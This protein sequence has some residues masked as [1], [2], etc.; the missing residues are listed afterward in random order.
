MW[1]PASET[2]IL[3]A[4]EAED[5]GETATFDAKVAL[6]AKGKS[7]DLAIDVAAMANDGGT[8]L[9]GIGEDENRRPTIPQPFRLAGARERVDQI[10]RTSISEPPA[11][12]VHA[13]PT[14]D[15]LSLG[16]LLVSVPPSLRA[17]H[18][19]TVG[20]EYR[21]YGRGAT[22]NTPLSEGEVA[23]LY[24]RRQRWEIDRSAMLEQVI[25]LAQIPP[26]EDYAFLHLIARPVVPDEDMLDKAR[27]DQHVEQFLNRQ[28]SDA[29]SAKVFSTRYSPDLHTQQLRASC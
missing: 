7:K 4:I 3:A 27:G 20:K 9:Y 28:F 5:M 25:D 19:V 18:M 6:P 26:H 13:L 15:D 14:D 8:L 16:Y 12:E 24:E 11:I 17:P 23:R 10:V 2:E 29:L 1:Q 22:G 21:Y